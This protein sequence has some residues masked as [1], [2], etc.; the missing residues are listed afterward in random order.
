MKAFRSK[1]PLKTCVNSKLAPRQDDSL[2]WVEE[3]TAI[4]VVHGIGNQLPL[5]T[6]DQFGRGLIGEYA[7]ED[8]IENFH[9]EHVVVEKKDNDKVWFD[10]LVRVRKVK[11]KGAN[12][13]DDVFED[14]YID[15]YEYYWANYTESKAD[16]DDIN[17]WL[18]GVVKGANKY[19]KRNSALGTECGDQ[20]AF[21]KGS[22]FNYLRY[23]AFISIMGN[24]IV[25]GTMLGDGIKK[26]L[27]MIP[28]VGLWFERGA[29]RY[30]GN[31]LKDIANIV[32][33]IVVYN[34]VDPKSKYYEIRRCI[35]DGAVKAIQFLIEKENPNHPEGEPDMAY[36]SILV[37]GHSLGSQVAYD[38]LNKI[39]FLINEKKIANYSC[40]GLCEKPLS[41]KGRQIVS[42][43]RGF[44]TF[45]S[46]LDK[47]AFFLRE[48]IPDEQFVRRQMLNNFHG[49]KQK[50]W[51]AVV[52][53]KPLFQIRNCLTR[54]L[55]NMQWR[56]YY[57]EKD[58][59]SGSL[60]YYEGL[61]NINC[62]FGKKGW[63][64][65]THSDY[66]QHPPF[67]RDLISNFLIS[68][69]EQ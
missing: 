23:K 56:N 39:N 26:L 68:R 64:A 18:Q 4:L 66:W 16:F 3:N 27:S 48:N 43:L 65:F 11:F 49:F 59:V 7:M 28:V 31:K 69:K 41:K 22:S 6:L 57:D 67:Y 37:A 63:R 5:E 60:D 61:T 13:E 35:L 2:D 54:R 24:I 8:S 46:P 34:V 21:F 29:H 30:T 36:P 1:T 44:I 42:Q 62:D 12:G 19:Y 55:D 47:I 15:L 33:D 10:N 53:E 58:Y 40:D 50:N 51:D 25:C 9:I 45:G 32:G 17:D 14:H 20:S 52:E 38:A